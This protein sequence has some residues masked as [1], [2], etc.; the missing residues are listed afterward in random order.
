MSASPTPRRSPASPAGH[1]IPARLNSPTIS[2]WRGSSRPPADYGDHRGAPGLQRHPAPSRDSAIWPQP[3]RA[4]DHIRGLTRAAPGLVLTGNYLEGVSMNDTVLQGESAATD[5]RRLL[6]A[7]PAGARSMSPRGTPSI[8]SAWSASTTA[9]CRRACAACSRST[10]PGRAASPN[11][12]AARAWSRRRRLRQHLQPP[13]DRA[14]RGAPRLRHR[15]RA[16]PA[17]LASGASGTRLRSLIGTPVRTRCGTCCGSRPRWI[18]SWS[19]SARLP[20]S[21]VVPSI[22]PGRPGWLD[23]GLNGLARIAVENAKELHQRTAIGAETVGVFT[24]AKEIVLRETAGLAHAR[25]AVVGLGE[26]GLL[27]ARAIVGNDRVELWCCRAAAPGH[28]RSSVRTSKAAP[29]DRW[30]SFQP[31]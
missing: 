15:A 5:A 10:T 8:G 25:V 28:A 19:G 11:S 12:F 3:H 7:T 2:C 23:K 27:T 16:R 31:C 20:S 29:S 1:T 24:L 14:Q 21:C 6:V 13:G 4:S 17:P 9:S 26:I 22:A 30:R 18:P